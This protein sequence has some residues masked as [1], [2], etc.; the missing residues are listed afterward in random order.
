MIR[1]NEHYEISFFCL[2]IAFLTGLI[3]KFFWFDKIAFHRFSI[4]RVSTKFR[5]AGARKERISLATPIRPPFR[6]WEENSKIES[7]M[8]NRNKEEIKKFKIKNKL[9]NLNG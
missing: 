5:L 2:P 4:K 6:F 7:E 1:L 9:S 8:A 3:V